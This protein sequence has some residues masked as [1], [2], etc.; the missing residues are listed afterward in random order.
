MTCAVDEV[1]HQETIKKEG[2]EGE[3]IENLTSDDIIFNDECFPSLEE[4]EGSLLGQ[5]PRE[6]FSEPYWFIN[7]S[8]AGHGGS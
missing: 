2:R 3:E 4:L 8:A 1:G 6:D 7:E 5:F